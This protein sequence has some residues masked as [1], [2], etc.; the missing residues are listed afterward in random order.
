MRNGAEGLYVA[1]GYGNYGNP[2]SRARFASFLAA[3]DDLA[4]SKQPTIQKMRG[5]FA[6]I[7]FSTL[8]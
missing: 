2:E 4:R 8:G 3:R 5:C 6:M 1:P 7:A